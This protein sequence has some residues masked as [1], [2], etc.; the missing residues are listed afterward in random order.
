[1]HRPIFGVN[2]S[3]PSAISRITTTSAEVF[4]DVTNNTDFYNFTA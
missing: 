4:N 1:M 2:N 3:Y